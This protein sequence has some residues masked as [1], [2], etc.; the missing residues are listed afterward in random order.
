[1]EPFFYPSIA[2]SISLGSGALPGAY[3]SLKIISP[4]LSTTIKARRPAPRSSF[5]ISYAL[6]TSPFGWKSDKIG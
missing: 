5:H 4:F 3:T 2:A 6:V 1:M